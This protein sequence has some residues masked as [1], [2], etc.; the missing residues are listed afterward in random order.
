[1]SKNNRAALV[2]LLLALCVLSYPVVATMWNNHRL[3]NISNEYK[4]KVNV[5]PQKDT[6]AEDLANAEKYNEW[7]H[8]NKFTP[9]PIGSEHNHKDYKMYEN[10]LTQ[11]NDT[12]G[13]ISIP[14]IN[15]E[16][17]IYHGTSDEAL[18]NGAGHLYGTYLPVGGEGQ[19]S[20]ITAHTGMVNASMF[21]S[22]PNLQIG[23]KAYIQVRDS[24]LAY[25]MVESYIVPA[26]AKDAIPFDDRDLLVLITC[27]PYGINSD[28]LIVVMERTELDEI[29][30]ISNSMQTWQWWMTGSLSLFFITLLIFLWSL[31]RDRKNNSL[32]SSRNNYRLPSGR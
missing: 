19:T 10:I 7:L 29:S 25:K 30:E 20:V 1:M 16:L 3:D 11:P 23:E 21:D 15:V 6:N 28:R 32:D 31:R 18:Y 27:T 2:L 24:K 9:P 5:S 17:P 26:D 8:K 12:M 13:I 22:L 4:D 14:D